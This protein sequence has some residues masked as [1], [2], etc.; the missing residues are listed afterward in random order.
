MTEAELKE[1]LAAPN[2]MSVA[3]NGRDGWP[4]LMALWY[5][6]QGRD[7]WIWT[8]AKSQ[9][10]RNLERDSKATLLVEQGE[11]YNELRGIMMRAEGEI[12]SEQ[13]TVLDVGE[14]IL[15][16]YTLRDAGQIDDSARA[17]LRSQAA[18]RVAVEFKVAS[19]VSW[20]HRKLG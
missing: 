13:D 18:K 5:V 4:H 3:T 7:P 15:R 10:V 8:Y 20:D 16:K 2:V 1:L 14:R 11:A 9:K 6:M 17:A 19:V 12:H